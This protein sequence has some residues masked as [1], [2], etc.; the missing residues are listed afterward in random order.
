MAHTATTKFETKLASPHYG[1]G[2]SRHINNYNRGS[3]G[4][5]R[6]RGR[7]NG[8]R[9]TCQLCGKIGHSA[10]ICWSRFDQNFM[11]NAPDQNSQA[12]N[13]APNAFLAS[14]ETL[15]DPSW[16]ADS[17]ARHP[18]TNNLECMHQKQDYNESRVISLSADVS[19]QESSSP[20]SSSSVSSLNFPKEDEWHRK[21]GHPSN[22]VLFQVLKQC[23]TGNRLPMLHLQ[24]LAAQVQPYQEIYNKTLMLYIQFM[25]RLFQSQFK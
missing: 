15:E 22:K 1:R 21:L 23:N 13:H 24:V 10:A 18:V 4:K 12:K 11:G 8:N 9:L 2:Q 17:G 3:R 16:Y 25:M 5:F 7:V 6:G 14:P 19:R 20:E